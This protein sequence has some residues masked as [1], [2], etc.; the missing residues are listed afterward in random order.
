MFG[1]LGFSYVGLIFLLMLA[2]P[3]ILWSRRIPADYSD[4]GENGILLFLE[5]VGEIGCA[6]CALMF[7]DFNCEPASPQLAWLIVALILMGLYDLCWLRY[8]KGRQRAKDMYRSFLRIP[9][10]LAVLPVAGF[11]LLGIYGKVIWMILFSVILGVGHIGIHWYH[12][13]R[14]GAL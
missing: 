4:E 7:A 10:P 5:R 8:F 2:I 14:L 13:K 12:A 1:H 9:I 3:N 6:V 11:L